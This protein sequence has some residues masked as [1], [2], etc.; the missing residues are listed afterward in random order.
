MLNIV[1]WGGVAL[2][3]LLGLNMLGKFT[4][5]DPDFMQAYM[6]NSMTSR[7]PFLKTMFYDGL[8]SLFLGSRTA[9]AMLSTGGMPFAGALYGNPLMGMNPYTMGSLP[10]S[11]M[12]MGSMA[13]RV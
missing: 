11:P 9:S 13:W 8:R 2:G 4:G 12:M 3:G 5:Q 7:R 6:I 1:K 10:Y